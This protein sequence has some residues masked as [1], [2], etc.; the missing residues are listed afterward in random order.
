VVSFGGLVPAAVVMVSFGGF[1]S[2]L[3]DGGKGTG[4]ESDGADLVVW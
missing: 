1:I 4:T 3:A 2:F